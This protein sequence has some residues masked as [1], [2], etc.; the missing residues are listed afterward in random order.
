MRSIYSLA[1]TILFVLF[2][3]RVNTEQPGHPFYG[4]FSKC[5]ISRYDTTS[6]QL[7]QII[8]DI[9]DGWTDELVGDVVKEYIRPIC[10]Y[11]TG[12][13]VQ[14][15]ATSSARPGGGR[16]PIVIWL[17]PAQLSCIEIAL[18]CAAAGKAKLPVGCVCDIEFPLIFL[19]FFAMRF[20]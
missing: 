1:Y 5:I 17:D 8:L 13:K 10:N 12:L 18:Q 14:E 11:L 6:L 7:V 3:S 19:T 15:E 4:D 2:A 20:L 16:L 9:R